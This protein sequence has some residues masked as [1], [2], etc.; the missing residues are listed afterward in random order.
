MRIGLIGYGKMGQAI[1]LIAIE[2]SHQISWKVT[3]NNP[4]IN[5]DF[6]LVDVVI[7]FTKPQLAVEHIQLS[8]KNNTPIVVGTTGWNTYLDEVSNEVL[9]KN[10]ALIHASNFSLGVNLFFELNEKLARL[11]NP[12]PQYNG[13]LEEIHHVQKLDS[14]SGTAITLANSIIANNQN[15]SSW[16][17]GENENPSVEKNQ[18]SVVAYRVPNVP[19]THSVEYSNEIDS[20]KIIHEAKNRKGFALG[21]VVAAEWLLDK[22]GVF[23]MKDVLNEHSLK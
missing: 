23:T 3:S 16:K 21:A 15:Y 17:V 7:E 10:G 19:G 13:V 1:E 11:M 2:R 4:L 5:Q 14:P 20:I 12:Y 6:S 18:L 22:K 9:N 8:L